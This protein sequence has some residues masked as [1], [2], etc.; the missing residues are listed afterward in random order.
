MERGVMVGYSDNYL[1]VVFNSTASLS[2]KLCR[3]KV[4]E[5]GVNECRGELVRVLDE[6]P[7]LA[8]AK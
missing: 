6:G 4:T 7:L 8:D 2:G 3:V 5:A 1:H